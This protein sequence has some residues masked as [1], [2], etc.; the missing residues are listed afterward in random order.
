MGAANAGAAVC[1]AIDTIAA[2]TVAVYAIANIAVAIDASAAATVAL[3]T[4]TVA[5]EIPVVAAA[6]MFAVNTIS[7]VS[8]VTVITA[9]GMGA[10]NA[11]IAGGLSQNPVT[12]YTKVPVVAAGRVNTPH[13][14]AVATDTIDS[15]AAA[16]DFSVH[17][18]STSAKIP[19][20]AA[21]RVHAANAAAA[22]LIGAIDHRIRIDKRTAEVKRHTN[23][24]CNVSDVPTTSQTR[25]SVDRSD[26]AATST[27]YCYPVRPATGAG[28]HLTRCSRIG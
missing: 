11:D 19:V 14:C 12:I 21:G 22:V 26:I 6:V 23:R 15:K 16:H 5:A 28:K 10:A 9:G 24:Q 17:S 7:A 27:G 4:I 13:A 3:H 18:L 1:V 8:E 20:V 25:T 2:V